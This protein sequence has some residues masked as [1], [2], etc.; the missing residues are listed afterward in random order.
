VDQGHGKRR[1]YADASVQEGY[2]RGFDH[3]VR[4][5]M[6]TI[7]GLAALVTLAACNIGPED[8]PPGP[9][10]FRTGYADGCNSGYVGAG[11]T[12]TFRRA[13]RDRDAFRSDPMYRDG[14]NQGYEECLE[15]EQKR[16]KEMAEFMKQLDESD[17][18]HRRELEKF[19]R[20][21]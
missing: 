18:R 11:T 1:C 10:T 19:M 17:E 4:A 20:T 12:L 14:W 6:R 21:P 2:Q 15:K 9:P 7:V 16:A 3:A 5:S 8:S 13:E